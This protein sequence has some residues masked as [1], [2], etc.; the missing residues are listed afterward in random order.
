MLNQT[1]LWTTLKNLFRPPVFEED[2]EK[3]RVAKLLHV[4][5]ITVMALV[6]LFSVPA[7]VM[8][9]EIGR[10]LIEIILA[11]WSIFMLVLLHRG[12]VRLTAFL[13]SFTLWLTVSYGTYEAGGF[14]GSIMSA[15]LGIIVIVAL[16][17][18]ARVGAIFGFLS[19]GITGWMLYADGRGWLPPTPSYATHTTFWI[20]FSAVVI[21]I[22][23][24]LSFVISSLQQ[25]L[26]RARRNEQEL[27]IKVEQV[28]VLAQKTAEANAFKSDLIARVSH[29]L[30]TPLGVLIGMSE[31]LQNN[32]Y[33][34][35]TA[36][37]Q[38]VINR[39]LNN[40]QT[41]AAVFNELLD[42]SQL[43]SGQL[44]LKDE[45]F[46]PQTLVQT[47]YSNCLSLAQRQ[48]LE[49]HIQVDP[50]LPPT[51]IGDKQRVE[52]IL[53]NLVVNAIKY[54]EAGCIVVRAHN[55]GEA[56]W[57]LQVTDTGVGMSEETQTYIFEPFRQA[58][59]TTRQELG[60][61]GL[62]LTIVQKLVT[63]MNGT[64]HI[65]SRVG[66]GSTFTVVL[67]LQP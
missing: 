43:E 45:P 33:G 32:V 64:I 4:I 24:L 52:Q 9:P 42:Q 18:G 48:G 22:V 55:G 13:F 21:G 51:V 25:A 57:L 19:I 31:M 2:E 16:L 63:A 37:Q 67:P 49:M 47:V 11:G 27:A 46:S 62:G 10:I 17:L 5:L 20:E 44:Q 12:R 38:D 7:Y 23:A 1:Y 59:T 3:T 40:S 39:I 15:Y 65:E 36:E 26:D 30:R 61:V 6:M 28:Q 66:Q 53:S 56:H 29:E 34:P 35:L 60:G 14:H 50:H 8:T 54:T 41:L 58:A